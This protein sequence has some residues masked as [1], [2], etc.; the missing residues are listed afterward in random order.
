MRV[1]SLIPSATEIV[2]ALGAQSELVGRSHE[3]DYPTD[4]VAL[5]DC[6]A[7]RLDTSLTSKEIDEQVKAALQTA[8]SV[9]ELKVDRLKQLKPDVIVTQAQ[10]DVC[11]VSLAD[12]ERAACES[13]GNDVEIVSLQPDCLADIWSD[14]RRVATALGRESEAEVLLESLQSRLESLSQSS[15]QLS[16]R[17][18]VV[19]IEW[20]DPLMTGGN[21][22]PEL[23]E[24]AG[25]TNM[26]GQPG[27]HS[28]WIDWDAVAN[29]D[30]DIIV[31]LPC[32]FDIPRTQNEMSA[33]A[34]DA[35]WLDLRAVKAGRVYLTDGNQFFNRPGPRVVES[36]EILAEIIH[37]DIFQFGHEG[38]GWSRFSSSDS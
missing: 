4:V 17:P 31:V 25:G 9:Y 5:P 27:K 13:L 28:P 38:S 35:R 16:E 10:C 7:P 1:V 21:W 37:P 23:V 2:S 20:I 29:A 33:I 32:G 22:V 11:A 8:L 6:S 24:L 14:I 19:T 30:P 3:C 36:A 15:S 26:L 18:R 12:V 34:G